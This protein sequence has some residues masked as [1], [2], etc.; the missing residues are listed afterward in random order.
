[1][2]IS[3]EAISPEAA[4]EIQ[5]RS[6]AVAQRKL[7]PLHVHRLASQIKAGDWRLTHQAIALDTSDRLI[8]GQHRIA[9]IIEANTTIEL[10]VARDVDPDVFYVIDTGRAR[11][12]A[13]ALQIIGIPSAIVVASAIKSLLKYQAT[14][15]TRRLWSNELTATVSTERVVQIAQS[16]L[17][18]L[19]R[20]QQSTADY[21][22]GGVGRAGARVSV[23]VALTAI[24]STAKGAHDAAIAEF[25]EKVATGAMLPPDSPILAYR[26]WLTNVYPQYAHHERGYVATIALLKTWQ[27]YRDGA[28]RS[29]LSV[30]PGFEDMP[31]LDAEAAEDAA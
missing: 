25:V 4:R 10:V 28:P 2:R 8:D 6:E 31:D 18:L 1:M 27:A 12:A 9:A 23:M 19:L 22:L 16:P 24:K 13:N 14:K 29:V 17:G 21:M 3:V 15:G 7:N 5:T 30:R 11:T 20:T 26:R